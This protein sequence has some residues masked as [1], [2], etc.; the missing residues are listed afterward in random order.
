M[1][2]VVE[3]VEVWPGLRHWQGWGGGMTEAA[4]DKVLVNWQH[5]GAGD[6][7]DLGQLKWHVAGWRENPVRSGGGGR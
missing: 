5:L 3:H 2:G 1:M 4:G 7:A 6:C